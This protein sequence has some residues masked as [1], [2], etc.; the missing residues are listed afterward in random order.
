MFILE[1]VHTR[2]REGLH[3]RY[4][5]FTSDIERVYV[6]NREGLQKGERECLYK[7]ESSE[8]DNEREKKR[9]GEIGRES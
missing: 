3:K 5:G 8:Q 7:I 2:E 9:N 1:W 4:R 6:R